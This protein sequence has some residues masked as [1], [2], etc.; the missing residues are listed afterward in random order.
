MSRVSTQLSDYDRGVLDERERI[1][2]A[3]RDKMCEWNHVGKPG[4]AVCA[5]ARM[6]VEA[7]RQ[8]S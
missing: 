4:C 3:I 5:T 1:L 7:I 8:L 6:L 2:S